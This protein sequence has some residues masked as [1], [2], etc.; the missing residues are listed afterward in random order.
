MTRASSF[1]LLLVALP[2]ASED[3]VAVSHF[4][5]CVPVAVYLVAALGF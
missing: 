5:G 1:L 3:A 4:H 2:T